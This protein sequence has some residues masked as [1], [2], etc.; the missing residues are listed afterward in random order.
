MLSAQAYENSE[1]LNGPQFL[2]PTKIF[3]TFA[4]NKLE[5]DLYEEM[6]GLKTVSFDYEVNGGALEEG[7]FQ[8]FDFSLDACGFLSLEVVAEKDS[9][10]YVLST[11]FCTIP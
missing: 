2:Q 5:C 3:K 6:R 10:F 8:L 1:V 9:V 4:G 11:R 7:L